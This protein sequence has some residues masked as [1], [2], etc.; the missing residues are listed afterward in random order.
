MQEHIER[1]IGLGEMFAEWVRRRGDLFEIVGTP[2]FALTCFRIRPEAVS[3]KENSKSKG[4]MNGLAEPTPENAVDPVFEPPASKGNS[5]SLANALTQIV[6]DRIT[7]RGEIFLTGSSAAGKTF[8]RVVSANPNAEEKYVRLAWEEIVGTSEEV[9]KE[10]KG[11]RL[12][13]KEM[14]NGAAH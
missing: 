5:D 9:L 3:E 7:E 4:L 2:M 14:Q 1:T 6:I 13:I 11:G 10:W 8:L 12:D